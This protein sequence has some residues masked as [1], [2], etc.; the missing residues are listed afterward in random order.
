MDGL[1]RR[2][3]APQRAFL[4]T[5]WRFYQDHGQW[6]PARLVHQH[7]GK[8]A[9]QIHLA[10]LGENLVQSYRENGKEQ[11]RL[12]FLGVLLTDQGEES[13]RLL[14][15]YLEYVR[16]LYKADP[17]V[18]WV[19]SAEVENALA[20]TPEQSRH[21]RQ[22][23]RLSHWWGGGS[24]FRGREWTVGVPIDVDDLLGES[25]LAR[26]VQKHVLTHF[27]LESRLA[28]PEP[29]GEEAPGGPFWFVPDSGLRQRLAA[30]WHE[31]QDV[32]HVR[33]WKSCIVL[34]GGILEALLGDALRRAGSTEGRSGQRLAALVERA[35]A[36][37][38]IVPGSL[39]LPPAL[40]AFQTLI[41]PGRASR[42]SF[43]LTRGE[44]E[45]ALEAVRACLRQLG[46]SRPAASPTRAR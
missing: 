11:Y 21:L 7:F 30:D 9:A 2:L 16:D 29:R 26:Y 27:P 33:G 28:G 36:Q 14:V 8:P 34:C 45:S 32:C 42:K 44:A 23:I 12:T 18:E 22:L 3:T 1:R 41:H 19:G 15:R 43:E 37:R 46:A 40:Q 5:L 4:S 10:E 25:D 24:A 38:L 6:V 31:A 20:L 35:S 39:V 13:E 17:R